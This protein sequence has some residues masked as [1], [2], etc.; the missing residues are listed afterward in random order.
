MINAISFKG[1]TYQTVTNTSHG[2][3]TTTLEDSAIL[4]NMLKLRKN[5]LIGVN[6]YTQN[7]DEIKALALKGKDAPVIITKSQR[8][9]DWFI[10]SENH[11]FS[12]AISEPIAKVLQ[13]RPST[14]LEQTSGWCLNI[15]ALNSDQKPLAQKLKEV[16]QHFLNLIEEFKGRVPRLY[17]A[18]LQTLN[19]FCDSCN[20]AI[21]LVIRIFLCRCE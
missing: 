2:Q 6:Q 13:R 20:V 5:D 10:S 16:N 14:I 7:G 9:Q 15:S 17:R 8:G 3:N 11:K 1:S 18:K 4:E 21:I 19:F 12:E